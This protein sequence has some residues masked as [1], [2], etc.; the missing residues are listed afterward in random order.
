MPAPLSTSRKLSRRKKLL[1]TA[2]VLMLAWPVVEFISWSA[3]KYA[4]SDKFPLGYEIDLIA[5]GSRLDKSGSETIHPFLGW[6]KN[7]QV[8]SG[9]DLFDR[10][11]PVNSLGFNDDEQGILK[12]EPGRVI[13]GIAGGS[14]AWQMSVAGEQALRKRLEESAAFRGK[15][16]RL[17][18]LAMSG[19]KQPQQLMALNYLLALGAEF[20]V[21]VNVDGYNEVALT[22]CENVNGDVFMA[23]PRMW[24]ARMQDVVDP[25]TY[26]VSYRLFHLRAVRQQL[27]RDRMESVFHWS[28]TLNVVWCLRDRLVEGQIIA[29]GEELMQRNLKEGRGFQFC[30][31]SQTW[32]GGEYPYDRIV[33]LWRNCS[34]QMCRVCQING[35]AYLQF[36]QPNQYLPG[37]KPM[38]EKERRDSIADLQ[39]Y[40]DCVAKGYP[41]MIAEGRN[42]RE[43]GV[44]FHDLTML[45]SNIEEPIYIDGFCHYNEQGNQDNPII[46]FP[47]SLARLKH[48]VRAIPQI[49]LDLRS[50]FTRNCCDTPDDLPAEPDGN[51]CF[52]QFPNDRRSHR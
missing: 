52:E 20:D 17:I 3:L 14:V 50:P 21:I 44:D 4:R 48:N 51:Q 8:N 42:L 9:T 34:L 5:K 37:S 16:I 15:D 1:F 40:G 30:G 32:D 28:P 26:S 2:I 12:R 6:V 24:H 43:R 7:P 45:F 10:H 35:I 31:P 38:G 41:L 39:C 18:R 49:S 19:Y 22:A 13:I 47:S 25:R 27:A 11:I 33:E 46:H 23:Y 29:L 36:L